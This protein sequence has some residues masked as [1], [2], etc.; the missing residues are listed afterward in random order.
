[1]STLQ[2]TIIVIVA[3]GALAFG[4]YQAHQISLLRDQVQMLRQQKEQ[5]AIL[6]NQVRELEKERDSALSRLASLSKPTESA[7]KGTNEVLKLRGEVGR[8]RRENAD[9]AS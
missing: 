8:L 4:L 5:Q 3:L 6:S 9:I 1:M 7:T 2:K